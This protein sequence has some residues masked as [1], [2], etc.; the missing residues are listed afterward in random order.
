MARRR[1]GYQ[2]GPGKIVA[3]I[4]PY[5]CPRKSKEEEDDE[6]AQTRKQWEE[7]LSQARKAKAAERDAYWE[8]IR[9]QDRV[10][11]RAVQKA[12][13]RKEEAK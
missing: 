8:E 1:R 4:Y 6:M 3:Y 13:L 12:R 7:G 9:R 2:E 10:H 11:L 5:V